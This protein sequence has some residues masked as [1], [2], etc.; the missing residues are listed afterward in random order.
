MILLSL[1]ACESKRAVYHLP[2]KRPP[3]QA[4]TLDTPQEKAQG[5]YHVVGRGETLWR[6][7]RAYGADLQHVAEINNIRD[8]TQIRVGQRLFIPGAAGRRKVEQA[9][10]GPG[11]AQEPTP[12]V[13]I[14]PGRFEWPV[15]GTVSSTFGV[16]NGMKHSGIDITAPMGT[17]VTAAAAGE[18]IYRGQLRGYG[19]ILILRHTDEFT[20][21]YAHLK[22]FGARDHQPVKQG[23]SIATVGDTGQADGAHLHF[24]IRVRNVARNP[25]FYLP[26]S[27]R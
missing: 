14:F 22:D 17:P 21:V 19:N 9:R 13:E 7:C 5:W 26:D 4:P 23:E 25:L 15:R 12:Q 24:E 20:T 1:A 10:E 2:A 6:I 11:A 3:A 18:V 16:R 8:V 27:A